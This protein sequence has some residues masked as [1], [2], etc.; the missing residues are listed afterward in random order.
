[1]V[2]VLFGASGTG[3]STA[4]QAISRRH[5]VTWL[6]V[7]DLRLALQY[8]RA[9]LPEGNDKL[10][11]FLDHPDYAL[12]PA[13]DVRRA[14]IGTAEAMLPAIRIVLESHVATGVPMVIEGDGILP[15]L[16]LDP[17]V[18]PLVDA[19][20]VR[21]C[22]VEAESRRELLDNMIARGRGMD[23]IDQ[24]RA[25]RQADANWAFNNWLGATSRTLGIPVVSTQPLATLA[26]RIEQM[27]SERPGRAGQAGTRDR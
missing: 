13:D 24:V 9:T 17:L 15:A 21:F 18:R 6:Q 10:Y 8:S 2:L 27:V 26:E 22:C 23:N 7:D 20:V 12:E 14:F 11:Y 5:G 16:A 4:A 3:K 25:A 1:M 19:G